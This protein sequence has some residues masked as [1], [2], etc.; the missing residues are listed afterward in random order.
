MFRRKLSLLVSPCDLSMLNE[1]SKLVL[2]HEV[3]LPQ[4]GPSFSKLTATF[5]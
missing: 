4:R 5:T 2:K 1:Y 3:I